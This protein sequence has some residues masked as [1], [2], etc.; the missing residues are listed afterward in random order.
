MKILGKYPSLR[1]RRNRKYSWTR[2]LVAENNLTVNDLILPI[3]VTEGKNKVE[4]I[5][6]MPG[7]YRYSLDKINHIINKAS[8]LGIPLVAIFP[9]TS[10]KKKNSL[11][12][13][14]LNEDNLVC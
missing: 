9:H 12:S 1:L 8:N 13:E 10:S 11:G 6:S 4:T 2:K 5:K 14:A 7:A 3:F